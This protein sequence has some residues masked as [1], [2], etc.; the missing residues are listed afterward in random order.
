[1]ARTPRVALQARKSHKEPLTPPPDAV[2]D[3]AAE[4]DEDN[5]WIDD[6]KLFL[7]QL[8][9]NYL[10]KKKLPQEEEE[11]LKVVVEG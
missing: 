3:T 5:G 6:L 9:M 8:L 1:M 11:S 7:N 4:S 10:L 2:D